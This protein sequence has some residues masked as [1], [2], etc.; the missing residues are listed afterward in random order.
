MS[1]AGKILVFTGTLSTDR[2]KA[3][4][5]AV[6][7]GAKVTGDVSGTTTHLVAG[8]GAGSKV[9]KAESKGVTIWT[10]DDFLAAVGSSGSG[11]AAAAPKAKAAGKRKPDEAATADDKKSKA[12]GAAAPA[13]KKGKAARVASD[14]PAAAS[15]SIATVPPHIA[16]VTEVELKG[17]RY[18][19]APKAS[20]SAGGALDLVFCL[21]CTGSMGSTI[22][23]CQKDIIELTTQLR[24]R[25][26]LDVRFALI[27][28][29][30]H[31]TGEEYCTKV[32]PFTRDQAQMQKNVNDQSANGGGDTPEA[33]TAS[34]FEALCI[35]WRPEA[36]K[37][38]VIMADAGPHGLGEGTTFPNGDPDGK[39]PLSI[40]REMMSLGVIVYSIITGSASQ[41]TSWFFSC[42]SAMTGGKCMQ[43]A[44][45]SAL[46]DLIIAG[47]T[48][49]VANENG[50]REVSAALDQ[51][52]KKKGKA[53]T[54]TEEAKET[55]R[56]LAGI[57][58]ATSAPKCKDVFITPPADRL[59][60][61]RGAKDIL[62]LSR[63]W[64]GKGS[65][66]V[67][68]PVA[69]TATRISEMAEARLARSTDKVVIECV[70]EGPKVR[71][72]VVSAGYDGN[73]NVQFP[74]DIRA[75]GKRFVVDLVVDAGS[76]YRVKGNIT[77]EK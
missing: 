3:T 63:L 26:G 9:T 44:N 60:Q 68:V 39:D 16:A 34:L 31:G 2:K 12:S 54:K 74:R 72:R 46:K 6:A 18:G 15:C 73:K 33:V 38:V 1:L 42:L 55:K 61:A 29:R 17:Y 75:A 23:A 47:A 8:P 77:E 13:A 67:A 53:L 62:E 69:D 70:K 45:S 35:E 21:D 7:A 4:A 24:D 76:F 50:V 22:A 27:P 10:E 41:K 20:G 25:A 59:E 66:A 51:L 49:A 40:A 19:E 28:Y 64:G 65:G 30:D 71:A 32:Y 36:A 37:Q 56:V 14:P 43:A 48:D 57:S 58:K 11:G 5:M 52:R